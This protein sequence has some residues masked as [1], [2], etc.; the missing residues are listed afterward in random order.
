[1]NFFLLIFLTI[2][3]SLNPSHGQNLTDSIQ[4]HVPIDIIQNA[5]SAAVPSLE[6]EIDSIVMP[7]CCWNDV[8][9]K[10][11]HLNFINMV[12]SQTKIGISLNTTDTQQLWFNLGLSTSLNGFYRLCLGLGGCS[13]IEGCKGDFEV[14]ML[15]TNQFKV[16]LGG[17]DKS[18]GLILT[19]DDDATQANFQLP[20][21]NLC[22]LFQSKIAPELPKIS[23]DII[24]AV[25][26]G[27]HTLST[28]L[29]SL[30]PA[31]LINSSSYTMALSLDSMTQVT[32][33]NSVIIQGRDIVLL[34]DGITR[35]PFAPSSLLPR[36]FAG[37]TDS[38]TIRVADSTVSN[39]LWALGNQ[40]KLNFPAFNISLLLANYTIELKQNNISWAYPRAV[41]NASGASVIMDL[42]V[43]GT[44]L[45]SEH[46]KAFTSE[47][48]FA[49]GLDLTLTPAPNHTET[50]TIQLL[51]DTKVL[52]KLTPCT[53]A[54]ATLLTL[55]DSAL[56]LIPAV[57]KVLIEHPIPLVVP[58]TLGGYNVSFHPAGFAELA[59]DAMEYEQGLVTYLKERKKHR[60]S[61]AGGDTQMALGI[62]LT[63][64]EI[65]GARFDPCV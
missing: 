10:H 56:A 55:L 33:A 3:F 42:T 6:Q 9:V 26:Q 24:T 58:Q 41:F 11:V 28:D 49:V 4:V 7:T 21:D 17:D 62:N 16:G 51:N 35:A 64:P 27:L 44:P 60:L 57:N 34:P 18:G 23:G 30:F 54:C 43:T 1:M 53:G 40:G 65:P 20:G 19:V 39:I 52:Q 14:D 47:F 25:N 2:A 45:S 13:T 8:G 31:T 61:A 59:L 46:G 5:I 12:I 63:C 32:S 37:E 50:L 38:V 22:D 48:L 36:S 29:Y 15:L